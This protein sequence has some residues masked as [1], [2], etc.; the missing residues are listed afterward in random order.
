MPDFEPF[1][2]AI[3]G[4]APFPWQTRLARKVAESGRWP[5]EIGVPTGLGKTAC[6]DIAV[7]WLALNAHRPPTER[8]APTRIWWVVNRRLLVDSTHDH[9]GKLADMLKNTDENPDLDAVAIR[10]RSL[11]A[12]LDAPPLE[13]IRLRGGV[14]SRTP[15][16]PSRPAIILCT[17]PM[18]GSRLLFRGY[19]SRLRAVDAA[20]A[21]TDSLVLLD[22]AHLA[23]HLNR[24]LPALAAC[25][26]TQRPPL[27]EH[28]MRPLLVALTA[29]GDAPGDSRV[30]RF[31]LDAQDL[32]HP[33]VQQRL[34]AAKPLE[35]RE[36]GAGDAATHLY[37]AALDLIQTAEQP[38]SVLVFANT[39][40]TARNVFNKL[41]NKLNK[42]RKAADIWLL[43]GRVRE[44]EAQKIRD[45]LMDPVNGMAAAPGADSNGANRP[46][47]LVVVATQTLEV[48]ADLDAEYLVTE[49]CG[50]RA[51]TQ[52]LG[53]LNR[54]GRYPRARALYLHLPSKGKDKDSWPVYDSEPRTVLDR[55]RDACAGDEQAV[56]QLPPRCVSTVL[57]PPCED[58]GRAPEV[59]P[60]IL[61][62]WTK[63]TT[64]PRGEAPVEPYFSGITA[65]E[66]AVSVIWRA[67]VPEPAE[68]EAE[69]SPAERLWPRAT[70]KEAIQIPIKEAEKVLENDRDLYRLGG[71][72]VTLERVSASEPLSPGD[73]IV[74]P[75]DRGLMDRY[76]WN[77][78]AT[79]PV[80]PV[81]DVALM[82]RGLPLDAGAIKRLCG[83]TDL[84]QLIAT[85]QGKSEDGADIDPADIDRDEQAKAVEE[86]LVALWDAPQPPDGD[87]DKWA[88]FVN[89]LDPTEV[90][91]PRNEIARLRTRKTGDE[92]P[93]DDFDE[94]STG[95]GGR[96]TLDQHCQ[97][98]AAHAC[99]I[100][101][102]IGLPDDLCDVVNCA[103]SLHDI[104]KSDQRFQRWLDPAGTATDLIAK[105]NTPRHLW[106]TT[107]GKSG[108][109]RGGRHEVLSARLAHAWLETSPQFP[110]NRIYRD[111]LLHL[112]ISHHSKGRPLVP[113]LRDDTDMQVTAT[114]RDMRVTA[115]AKLCIVDWSQP[116]RF[117]RLNDHFGP[118]GLAL[119][120]AVVICADHA[121]SGGGTVRHPYSESGSAP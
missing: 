66:Y 96:V 29:T 74:L 22:E 115:P 48:G 6:L 100:A 94:R 73:C 45:A 41:D 34:D 7:W 1:Y 57:G 3:N 59:M 26:P 2:A 50:V 56:V 40:N 81:V 19:G 55:L 104:G 92:P 103:A 90:I 79:D 106:P 117:R 60:E 49:Q 78:D 107:R 36:P 61:R 13:V 8:P 77:P 75:S 80:V 39:P 9:A 108:W 53:R 71:D 18:Y 105:S 15:A 25:A 10:L 47:H 69:D 121:I 116:G 62:E 95:T 37:N 93:L 11:S 46:R 97:D 5:D 113:P 65:P 20:M 76:G 70:D 85:A 91:T 86:I 87:A 111:L 114:V 52:R 23:P 72:G 68:P 38:A 58:S 54:L 14:A 32:A 17:L 12:D 33:V 4:R 21:C 88:D 64:P 16:D 31:D 30:D 102:R 99:A 109:P 119:L 83:V 24:L 84:G 43:T 63:T 67:Y 42:N 112:I 110:T 35:L 28:R 89:A 101:H 82:D 118:W 98:V 51:L 44:R 27:P 120:E